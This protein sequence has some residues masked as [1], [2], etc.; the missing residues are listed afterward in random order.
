MGKKS[1]QRRRVRS[2]ISRGGGEDEAM[3]TLA[4]AAKPTVGWTHVKVVC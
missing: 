1:R 2:N 4:I 3:L